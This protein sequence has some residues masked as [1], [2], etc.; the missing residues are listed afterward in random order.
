MILLD[1]QVLMMITL[2]NNIISLSEYLE[3]T[4]KDWIR[5]ALHNNNGNIQ[6]AAK[7]L[8]IKRT[9]LN[10]KIKRLQIEVEER[11]PLFERATLEAAEL[12]ARARFLEY[13]LK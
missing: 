4:E 6:R 3:K 11:K 13:F 1:E 2:G 9:T 5:L 8:G 7:D 12:R 10:E